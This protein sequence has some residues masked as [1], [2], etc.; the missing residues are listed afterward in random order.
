MTSWSKHLGID[1]TVLP[2]PKYAAT[3]LTSQLGLT[4]YMD[5]EEC[6]IGE[7]PYVNEGWNKG[8]LI[9]SYN[10]AMMPIIRLD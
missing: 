8:G 2:L 3:L 7:T 4:D 1:S 6:V 5:S 10:N 9:V